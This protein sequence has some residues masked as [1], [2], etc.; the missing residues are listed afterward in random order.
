MGGGSSLM[1]YETGKAWPLTP[2][3]GDAYQ[4]QTDYFVACVLEGRQP[5]LGTPE[6][7]RLAVRTAN[8]VRQ[9]FETGNVIP[10]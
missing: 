6:Q 8:A 9:S 2:K 3:P 10:V 7:A 1:V 4:N 5:T